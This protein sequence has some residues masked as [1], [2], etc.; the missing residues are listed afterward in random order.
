MIGLLLAVL[1]KATDK[2]ADC[3]GRSNTA[4]APRRF[5]RADELPRVRASNLDPPEMTMAL[6]PLASDSAKAALAGAWRLARGR[7]MT[8]SP[9]EPGT[10]K[11]L[12][13]SLWATFEGPHAGGP[14]DSG[15]IVLEKGDL[16]ALSAHQRLV[17]EPLNRSGAAWFVWEAVH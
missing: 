5:F 8:L 4:L 11:V 6:N 1:R 9:H 15:D 3:S 17:V 10:L 12:R 13:G 14:H 16:L 7:A 2:R